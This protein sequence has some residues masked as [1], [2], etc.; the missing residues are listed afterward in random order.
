[1]G[2]TTD[3]MEIKIIIM[4]CY[5]QRYANTVDDLYEMDKLLK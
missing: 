1:M 5:E 2:I 4:E 3:F